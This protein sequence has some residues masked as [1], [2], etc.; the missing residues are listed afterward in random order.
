MKIVIYG[1]TNEI[2]NYTPEFWNIVD[3]IVLDDEEIKEKEFKRKEIKKFTELLEEKEVFIIVSII[4]NRQ[5]AFKKLEA[6]GYVQKRD[7]VWAP[8][9]F[10]ERGIPACYSI[11]SW[12]ENAHKYN[13]EGKEGPWDD[14]YRELITL[15]DPNCNALMDCGAGNMS[16][17]RMINAGIKYYPVDNVQRYSETIVCDFNKGNFPDIYVDT[18]VACGILEYII[19]PEIFIK[20]MCEHSNTVLLSYCSLQ[21]RSDISYR[22]SLGWKNHLTEGEIVKIFYQ[23]GFVIKDEIYVNSSQL[24]LSFCKQINK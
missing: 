18:I 24:Y 6:H 5:K 2:E 12:E 20:E 7:F 16:L 1:L 22:L 19:L 21:M 8:E 10:G 9:W 23:N 17:K 4:V 13:F 3:Y 15:L 11:N 14:R